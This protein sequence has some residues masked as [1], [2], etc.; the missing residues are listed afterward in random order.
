VRALNYF[1]P[2]VAL[3]SSEALA[4]R[5]GPAK[6]A[7]ELP[8]SAI[9]YV[10]QAA[11]SANPEDSFRALV[12]ADETAGINQIQALLGHT[13]FEEQWAFVPSIGLWIKVGRNESVTELDSEVQ[14]DID[15]LKEIVS[16]YHSVAIV[17]FHPAGFY[18]RIW[19]R[20]PYSVGFP[21]AVIDGDRLQPIG[22]ALPSP[23]DVISSIELSRMFSAQDPSAHITYAVVSPHG[24]VTYGPTAPGL[25]SIAYDWGNPRATTARSIVNRIAIRR[26]PFNIAS[27]ISILGRPDIGE[28]IAN[29]CE[30]V[31]GEDYR[32]TFRPSHQ[33]PGPLPH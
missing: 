26:M 29:L 5:N 17:H 20:E 4:A 31:S 3:T 30:Q 7:P 14:I 28:V 32:L 10:E 12:S 23:N 22:F 27:T 13:D 24:V 2:V 25:K 8:Q 33:D 16:L 19:Q 6:A 18:R 21:A 15:Y 9:P 11:L 1:L